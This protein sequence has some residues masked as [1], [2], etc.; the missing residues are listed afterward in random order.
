MGSTWRVRRREPMR[1]PSR[2]DGDPR[3]YAPG[4]APA[5]FDRSGRSTWLRLQQDHGPLSVAPGSVPD[6]RLVARSCV[7]QP[8]VAGGRGSA[9][10]S[11]TPPWQEAGSSTGTPASCCGRC[12]ASDR[13]P[14]FVLRPGP[15]SPR[16]GPAV[17]RGRSHVQR[18]WSPHSAM[19]GDR[20]HGRDS[21]LPSRQD[22]LA[23]REAVGSC[24]GG[25]RDRRPVH[26]LPAGDG[27]G[28]HDRGLAGRLFRA[29][30]RRRWDGSSSATPP[31]TV[32]CTT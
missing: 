25:R 31:P 17:G 14:R 3:P 10:G 30:R 15:D 6:R 5:G 32:C 11:D 21:H 4:P 9:R 27:S 8:A 13:L 26:R 12:T 20:R 24:R 29:G 16:V 2:Q 28:E 18:S 23:T 7:G 22:P 1:R 19:A